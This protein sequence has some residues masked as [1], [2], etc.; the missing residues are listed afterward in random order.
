MNMKKML[1]PMV[2]VM[3]ILCACSG[4]D[5]KNDNDK[6]S[7]SDNSVSAN[8]YVS[9]NEILFS[10]NGYDISYKMDEEYFQF[11]SNSDGKEYVVECPYFWKDNIQ[12]GVENTD[13]VYYFS[14]SNLLEIIPMSEYD[15]IGLAF[16]FRLSDGSIEL[17][18]VEEF[19]YY[20]YAWYI[21]KEMEY[22]G[23]LTEEIYDENVTAVLDRFRIDEK[24]DLV[25][26][27]S[28]LLTNNEYVS[29]YKNKSEGNY[30]VFYAYSYQDL[31][32]NPKYKFFY[33]IVSPQM[34]EPTYM[35]Q[36]MND[37]HAYD[38]NDGSEFVG[39][40]F[41]DRI[42]DEHGYLSQYIF[43]GDL[44]QKGADELGGNIG[45]DIR[46]LSISYTYDSSNNI[47]SVTR[48][49]NPQ[50]WGTQY[51]ERTYYYENEIC[52]SALYYVTHGYVSLYYVY[53]DMGNNVENIIV[54]DPFSS[55]LDVYK[56][57]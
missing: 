51:S 19:D 47:S 46:L 30:I 33:S 57:W 56:A 3:F 18:D 54:F 4:S 36:E 35:I 6:A 37:Y 40:T 49:Q 45:D 1:F 32:K 17:V 11:V 29:M 31:S 5:D 38:G 23:E 34:S 48:W 26:D 55:Y 10:A 2:I 53:S 16:Y 21:G 9:G 25:Y 22:D 7:I 44:N 8:G 20:I 14:D 50:I 41:E 27:E 13:T 42:V 52:L 43:S 12:K 39:T 24:K 15:D 28:D